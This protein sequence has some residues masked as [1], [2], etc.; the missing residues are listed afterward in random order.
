MFFIVLAE[1]TP[2]ISEKEHS[3]NM[4]VIKKRSD[5]YVQYHLLNFSPENTLR[6][7]SKNEQHLT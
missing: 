7:Y 6:N 1:T 4:N 2:Q 5:L 3:C